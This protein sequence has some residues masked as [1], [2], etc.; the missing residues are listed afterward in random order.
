MLS[1]ATGIAVARSAKFVAAGMHAGDHFVY[2]DCRPAFIDSFDAAM[3]LGNEGF[4]E[5]EVIA[6]FVMMTKSTIVKFGK[7]LQVPLEETWSCY[8]GGRYHCGKCGTCVERKE[9]FELAGVEDPT[10]YDG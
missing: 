4:W 3:A 5:G 8:K 1:I 7:Q 10:R 9:A 6:P 2:P